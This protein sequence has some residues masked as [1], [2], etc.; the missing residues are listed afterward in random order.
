DCV[1]TF[2][3]AHAVP[4][5]F[6]N[7]REYAEFVAREVV[8]AA[9]G[10]A[11][12]VDVFCDKGAFSPDEARIVLEAGAREGMRVKVHAE[13]L[14]HTGGASLAAEL[15]ATSAD[16]LLHATADDVQRLTKA[17]VA[18]VLLPTTALALGGEFANARALIDAGA[19]V[20]LAS[21]LSPNSYGESMPLAMALACTRMRM[22]PAEAITASTANAAA[23]VGRANVCG[24]LDIGKQGDMLILDATSVSH[25]PYRLG[26][27]LAWKVVKLGEVVVDR[28]DKRR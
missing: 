9:A 3:G 15:G 28:S 22:T 20:A 4:P 17:N 5:E 13:E 12:Y 11:E 18:P 23:A 21:D 6:A 10:S 1:P 27:N 19:P 2:L 26:V 25:L 8:P 16:H 14:A 7:A 24:S